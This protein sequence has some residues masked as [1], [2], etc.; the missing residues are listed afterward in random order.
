[1][2]NDYLVALLYLLTSPYCNLSEFTFEG[3]WLNQK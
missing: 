2:N 1:M 3:E